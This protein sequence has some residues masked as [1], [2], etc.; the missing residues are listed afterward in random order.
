MGNGVETNAKHRQGTGRQDQ[1]TTGGLTWVCPGEGAPATT[2]GGSRGLAPLRLE[3]RQGTD[4]KARAK[5]EEDERRS[6]DRG[7]AGAESKGGKGS[8]GLTNLTGLRGVCPEV[9]TPLVTHEANH[10]VKEW[11]PE[12]TS[13]SGETR[14]GGGPQRKEGRQDL[15]TTGGQTG[16][17]PEEGTP[18]TTLSGS[19]WVERP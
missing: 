5:E 14:Q 13:Q 1:E 17:C 15:A 7:E 3:P 8:R 16:V 19:Q 18:A 10:C 6:D 4:G 9:G 12:A 2:S 11:F